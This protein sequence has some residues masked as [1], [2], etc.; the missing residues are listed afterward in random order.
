MATATSS[1]LGSSNV[2]LV[3]ATATVTTKSSKNH[4][5]VSLTGDVHTHTVQNASHCISVYCIFPL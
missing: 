4:N 5:A 2:P 1:D 3:T